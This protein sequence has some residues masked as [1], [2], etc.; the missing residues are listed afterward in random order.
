MQSDASQGFLPVG[1]VPHSVVVLPLV[2]GCVHTTHPCGWSG[3]Q[4][5]L[6]STAASGC[7]LPSWISA[8]LGLPTA[9][10]RA[11]CTSASQGFPS[12]FQQPE[13][14]C[15]ILSLQPPSQQG[16]PPFVLPAQLLPQLG[17]IFHLAW[18]T[19]CSLSPGVS[20]PTCVGHRCS[21]YSTS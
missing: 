12:T 3:N 6:G 13:R 16:L 11:C 17:F 4:A 7:S 20:F 9:P 19:K 8:S 2:S 14:D 5:P 1:P 18:P 21:R 10:P 15:S